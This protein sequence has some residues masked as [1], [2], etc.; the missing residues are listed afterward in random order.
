MFLTVNATKLSIDD[1]V[2]TRGL[3]DRLKT[4]PRAVET[5]RHAGKLPYLKL[6]YRTVRFSIRAV[7]EALS[8]YEVHAV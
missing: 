2:D 7:E 6:G 5:M 4:T 3:A 1:I 8:K